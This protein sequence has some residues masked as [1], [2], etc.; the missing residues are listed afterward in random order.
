MRTLILAALLAAPTSA[1]GVLFYEGFE[2]GM[3]AW[4]VGPDS[5]T[6][7]WG[8]GSGACVG[9]WW[10]A[11]DSD[12]CSPWAAP[13]PE[14]SHAG[15]FG[16]PGQCTYAPPNIFDVPD[17]S[18]ITAA[19]IALPA[20]AG[21]IHL[22]FWSKSEG[23]DDSGY[24]ER[25]I[26]ISANGGASWTQIGQVWNSDWASHGFD[27]TPWAGQ[28]VK[29]KFRF[30]GWDVALN[31]YM[32]WYLD[33]IVVETSTANGVAFCSGDGSAADCPCGNYGAPAHGCATSIFASGARLSGTGAARVS[34]D[35]TQLAVEAVSNSVVTF[36]QGTTRHAFGIGAT[37][38]DGLRCAGG[39]TVR[40][41]SVLAAGNAAQIP[42]AG[43]PTIAQ[44]GL[45]PAAG[46]MR[47]YQVWYRNAA[48]FCTPST[49]NLSNGLAI[50]WRP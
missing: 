31:D 14:G 26:L 22:R 1:Q 47:T 39:A 33:Q 45:I 46:G 32:G 50:H 36:F 6:C 21:S 29:L 37:F 10:D 17:C 43:Q 23:E 9:S 38:G 35:T 19:P 11:A 2:S 20:G 30:Q 3:S 7:F 5:P 4:N 18:M 42:G 40:L 41:K 28:S 34:A 24:D 44:L 27:L 48:D 49:F 13:F 25:L 15:R 8:H 16:I 12:P